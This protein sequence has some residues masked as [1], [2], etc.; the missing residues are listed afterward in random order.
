MD[1]LDGRDLDGIG[2]LKAWVQR[3]ARNAAI[4]L[5]RRAKKRDPLDDDDPRVKAESFSTKLV[6]QQKV[7]DLV[8]GVSP[9]NTGPLFD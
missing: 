4:D 7:R 2:N 5:Q 1:K 6:A 9:R 8:N 3:V